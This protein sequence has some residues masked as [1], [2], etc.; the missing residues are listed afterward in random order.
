MNH[1]NSSDKIPFLLNFSVFVVVVYKYQ[2]L[3]YMNLEPCTSS[4]VSMESGLYFMNLLA[5][6]LGRGIHSLW[7]GCNFLPTIGSPPE[8]VNMHGL[9]E[10]FIKYVLPSIQGK[11]LSRQPDT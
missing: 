2:V 5:L 10:R 8:S 1:F 11:Q 3:S 6:V 9:Q 7:S 4:S